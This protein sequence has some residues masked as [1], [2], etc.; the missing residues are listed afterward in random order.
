MVELLF[1]YGAD[2]KAISFHHVMAFGDPEIIKMFVDHGADLVTNFPLAEGLI[3]SP[4]GLLRLCK[5]LLPVRPELMLQVN[6]ALRH[7][8][9]NGNMR[10]VSPSISATSRKSSVRFF[11]ARVI[12]CSERFNRKRIARSIYS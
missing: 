2:A 5:E 9:E 10:G 4:R 12:R 3:R 8:S 1:S 7:F 6:T 11:C